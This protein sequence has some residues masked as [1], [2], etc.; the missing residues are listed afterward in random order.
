M[1]LDIFLYSFMQVSFT[2]GYT[3]STTSITSMFIQVKIPT[4]LPMGSGGGISALC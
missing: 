2:T 4:M 3:A 1:Q